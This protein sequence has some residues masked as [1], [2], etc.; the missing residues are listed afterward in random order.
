MFKTN[1][2]NKLIV[3]LLVITI[4]PFGLSIFVTFIFTKDSLK[5][6]SIQENV[7]LLYQGKINIQTYMKELNNLVLSSYNNR[8][9]INYLRSA[10]YED[11]SPSM[12]S[13]NQ[14][15]QST[16]YGDDS[17]KKVSMFIVGNNKV[18]TTSKQSTIIYS[19]YVS[20]LNTD[21][22]KK[23]RKSPNNLSM[24]LMPN[25]NK[26]ILH[27]AYKNVPTESVLAYFSLEVKLD[28]INQLSENL[29][30]K[31]SDEFYIITPEGDLVFGS[32][33]LLSSNEDIPWVTTL[34]NKNEEN[35]QMEWYD[36]SF[37][38]V[39]I[40][41]KISAAQG[42][43]IIVKRIPFTTLYESAYSVATINIVFGMI[44]LL[45]VILA[46]I[47]VSF[48]FSKPIRVLAEN[49]KQIEKGNM[50]V[51]FSSLGKDEIGMLGHR[52]KMM[53]ERLNHYIN[54]EYKLELENKTNQ[55]KVLQSQ[56][57]PHFLYNT[58]QSIGT[59]ALK[60]K[61]PEIYSSLTELSQIMRYNMKTDENIVPLV[62]EINYTNSY[63]LL[64]KQRFSDDLQ[65]SVDI[66][67]ELLDVYVPKMILQP[68]IE[69]YF[70]HGFQK[71][72]SIGEINLVCKKKGDFLCIDI[73][74]NGVGMN[75]KQ[76]NDIRQH[77]Y[78]ESNK[79]TDMSHIGLRNV[80]RRL[81]LYYPEKATLELQNRFEGG[82]HVSMRL[83]LEMEV[84]M[85][86]ST[87]Y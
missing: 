1:I 29:Y 11:T 24:E 20:D 76:L 12:I 47:L 55:L 75:E 64:Q 17:V 63:M 33:P 46:S 31:N 4:I 80:Y 58:L 30:N 73:Y 9:Y 40:F 72:Y 83:P 68:I 27:R 79:K 7:N 19:D 70:K 15:L 57:N 25:L 51:Q 37:Q 38:G 41:D 54:R 56:V 48:K 84:D 42:G 26:F 78:V 14:I 32:T 13:V 59:M 74:D 8:E 77:L 49:I 62:K 65:Y 6:Q 2:R 39:M 71:T 53:V 66:D 21:Y 22:F 61:V 28:K 67:D 16:L 69:N 86:E 81:K 85:D 87:D 23:A 60:S 36:K 82:L 45:L 50:Q 10:K 35:G 52:F 44:G 43:W 5:E 34:I 18:V 3:L